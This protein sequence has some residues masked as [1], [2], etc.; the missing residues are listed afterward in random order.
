MGT[1]EDTYGPGSSGDSVL[2]RQAR[3]QQAWYR[4]HVR[5]VHTCGQSPDSGGPLRSYLPVGHE[6]D[7][8]ISEQ[9]YLYAMERLDDKATEPDL[10]IAADRLKYNML[11]SHCLLYT[12]PS[13][14][15]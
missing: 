10:T 2:I 15:D 3:L 11:S 14:R 7:N 8:F 13:P 4:V 9:A 1:I 12:S 6:R 5:G